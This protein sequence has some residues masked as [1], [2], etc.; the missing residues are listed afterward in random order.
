VAG[1]QAKNPMQDVVRVLRSIDRK[2][3]VLIEAQG[4]EEKLAERE[5]T[6]RA[7]AAERRESSGEQFQR[8]RGSG[9]R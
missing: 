4:L 7:T 6:D 5:A 3:D 1:Q 9:A 8:A 2:L